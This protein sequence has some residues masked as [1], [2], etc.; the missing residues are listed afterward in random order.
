MKILHLISG[1]DSGG[2]EKTLYKLVTSD[3][4]NDHTIISLTRGGIFKKKLEKKNIS[5][6]ILNFKLNIY[7]FHE[8]FKLINL[9]KKIKPNLIQSWMYKCN[10]ITIFIKLFYK[11]DVY[12]NIRASFY[13]K[14]YSPL[15]Q[16]I[17]YFSAIA[18]HLIPMKIIYCSFES[19]D[20]HEKIFFSKKKSIFIANGFDTLENINFEKNRD[21]LNKYHLNNKNII[22]SMIARFD[23]HKKHMKLVKNFIRVIQNNKNVVLILIGKNVNMKGGALYKFIQDNNMS[24]N[25]IL[26]DEINNLEEIYSIIDFHIL[27]SH[28][29][30]FP[31]VIA[32]SMS[33]GIPNIS[34]NVGHAS[35]IINKSGWIV[36]NDDM[37]FNNIILKAINVYN[38]RT[39]F[40]KLKYKCIENISNRFSLKSMTKNYN[41][42]WNYT[43]V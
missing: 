8:F 33:R 22:F 36:N 37:D 5:I 27:F 12:W 1:L 23:P 2:A 15:N 11:V 4:K 26:L 35:E 9:I 3:S 21:I 42:V 24:N 30:S 19:I 14:L 34:S 41:K 29:E 43:N 32:E 16:L 39:E 28:S 31:N 18:S 10:F 20:N 17:I 6:Y 7:F 25:I 38:N 13:K 40:I